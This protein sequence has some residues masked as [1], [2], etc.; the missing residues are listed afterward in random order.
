MTTLCVFKKLKLIT[1]NIDPSA[2]LKPHRGYLTYF[3]I[4]FDVRD[5]A[6]PCIGINLMRN[7]K[8]RAILTHLLRQDNE[9]LTYFYTL[10]NLQTVNSRKAFSLARKRNRSG[11]PLYSVRGGSASV[12]NDA[13]QGGRS[14]RIYGLSLHIHQAYAYLMNSKEKFPHLLRQRPITEPSRISICSSVS[15]IG[16]FLV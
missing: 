5:G 10:K 13:V 4:Q 2:V 7:Y 14:P 1:H 9:H 6:F 15:A 16:L 3:Y 12:S 8:I 11:S